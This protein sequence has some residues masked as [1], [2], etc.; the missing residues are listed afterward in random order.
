MSIKIYYAHPAFTEE[1]KSFKVKLLAGLDTLIKDNIIEI[2][3]PF[4]YSPNIEGDR[5]TKKMMSKAVVDANVELINRSEIVLASIDDR[6]QGVIWEMGYAYAQQKRIITM[7]QQ[8]YDVNLML[9]GTVMCHIPK[10]LDNIKT[11][12]SILDSINKV[13]NL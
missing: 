6:D 7:S 4:E 3:D 12:N 10:V 11:L 9:S 1:Q 2:L 13:S 5:D 8:E